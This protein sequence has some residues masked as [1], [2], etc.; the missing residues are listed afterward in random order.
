MEKKLILASSSPRRIELLG[1][2][3]LEFET[4]HPRQVDESYN[5][6]ESPS[7]YALRISLD[8]GL[9]VCGDVNEDSII[10]SADTIVVLDGSIYGKPED[11]DEAFRTLMKLSSR[12][13]EVITAFSVITGTKEVLHNEHVSTKVK[14]KRLASNEIESYIKTREPMDKAG[15]YAIQGA[16]AFM[17]ESINGSYTNVVGLPLSNL[18]DTLNKLKILQLFRKKP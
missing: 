11:K 17:V 5:G 7:G 3:G 13:H 18:V 4:V 12:T 2:A 10:V 1:S 15:S 14:F 6:T 16:G 9:S 8:K